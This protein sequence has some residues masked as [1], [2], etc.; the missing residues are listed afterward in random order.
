[1]KPPDAVFR[2][3]RAIVLA[4]FCCLLC[5]RAVGASFL[6][7][8]PGNVPFLDLMITKIHSGVFYQGQQNAAFIITVT[9]VGDVH[10]TGGVRVSDML[11]Q[12]LA[13][14]G[15][16]DSLNA[17]K[18]TNYQAEWRVE[19][20]RS[21]SLAPGASTSFDLY[22]TV[23]DGAPSTVTNVIDL[24][25][26]AD[27]NPANNHAEDT[28]MVLTGPDLSMAVTGPD[29]IRE[30]QKDVIYTLT[31]TNNGNGPTS[32]P[33]A[34]TATPPAGLILRSLGGDGWTCNPSTLICA[35]YEPLPVSRSYPGLILKVDVPQDAPLKVETRAAV[36][37]E[38]EI[39]P[40]NNAASILI[41]VEQAADL[42]V[43][44]LHDGD[45][46]QGQPDALYRLSV[47]NVE[48]GKT[49]RPVTVTDMLPEGLRAVSMEGSGWDC[50]VELVSCTYASMILP[51]ASTPEILLRV[52]VAENAP[53]EVTNYATVSGGG[54]L[55]TANNLSENPT[56]IVQVPDLTITKTH[57]GNF[58]QGQQGA[59]YTI[60]VSN[61]GAGPVFGD[62][63]VQEILPEDHPTWLE[64][65]DLSGPGW[66]CDI[67]HESYTCTREDDLGLLPG[68]SYPPIT[69]TV[70]VLEKMYVLRLT[71]TAVVSGGGE[72]NTTNNRA[73]DDTVILPDIDLA[74]DVSHDG[75][76]AQG[77]Q[78]A[79][80]HLDVR[81]EGSYP[82]QPPVTVTSTL[83]H[84]LTAK[85]I[86]GDGWLCVLNTLT[87]TYADVPDY[88][89][90]A[91]PSITLT[92]DVAQNAP[93]VVELRARVAAAGD[94]DPS[95]DLAVDET[96]I[97]PVPDLTLSI[98]HSGVLVRGKAASA[99]ALKVTNRGGRTTAP[100][101]VTNTLPDGL[102][103][104]G[105]SGEGWSCV[106]ASRSCTRA[107][108][109]HGGFDYPPVIVEVGVL[110]NAPAQI[111]YRAAVSG[112]VEGNTANN[113]AV[114]TIP[115]Y[116]APTVLQHPQDTPGCI[117]LP[118]AFHAQAEGVPAPEAQWQFSSDGGATWNDLEGS[119]GEE[120]RFTLLSYHA[121]KRFR[122]VFRSA[123]GE[124][125]SRSAAVDLHEPLGFAPHPTHQAAEPGQPVTFQVEVTGKPLQSLLWQISRDGAAW[126]AIPQASGKT[127]TLT[128]RLEMDGWQVRAAA[129]N[130]CG[131]FPSQPARIGIARKRL[132]L[133]MLSR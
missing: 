97:Y 56:T 96:A 124:V 109:L 14:K 81:I 26:S 92:V 7:A 43:T 123:A 1:M 88:G 59:Q 62:V 115:V 73:E 21:V 6:L 112:G 30:G 102:I 50:S 122:A 46:R 71:N 76:F 101:T 23:L 10:Y 129:I 64:I 116:A 42:T 69:V 3:T 98:Q 110:S 36:T 44:V 117:G 47:T 85:S 118:I 91:Y 41:D 104:T 29:T 17:W 68:G 20:S 18:C 74:I 106:L 5:T 22:T 39:D 79:V 24:T 94:I 55:N 130:A 100:V 132:Y 61:V 107:D 60:T 66:A 119:T 28:V 40:A 16:F 52:R 57:S 131:V 83:P 2:C 35:R 99:F 75:P 13:Y 121:D 37:V 125:V 120:L 87:C 86:G 105:I 33:V 72:L 25:A 54:E 82:A 128:P 89:E 108:L 31:V 8:R 27:L 58:Y 49:N 70:N 4:L 127:L 77:Q 63:L 95:D 90:T 53:P 78:G 84:G 80:Y 34:V 126:E 67:V 65:T 114:L 15:F 51:L 45:F 19:C 9:N 113:T 12:S 48:A 32:G 93:S 38:R 103:A 111:T 11:P 133:P